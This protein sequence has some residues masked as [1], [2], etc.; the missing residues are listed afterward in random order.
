MA[1]K[2][3]LGRPRTGTGTGTGSND[4]TS[5]CDTAT[6]NFASENATASLR[7][8]NHD[9]AS[10]LASSS[11]KFTVVSELTMPCTEGTVTTSTRRGME[12][13]QSFCTP[14]P[15]QRPLSNDLSSF[16][17]D[18]LNYK[19][20]QVYG[21]DD[22]LD[23]LRKCWTQTQRDRRRRQVVMVGGISGSGKTRLVQAALRHHG[24][25]V[26]GKFVDSVPYSGI[27]TA[28]AE[29]CGLVL[30][31]PDTTSIQQ[32]LVA[33]NLSLLTKVIPILAEV[34]DD[35]FDQTS[36]HNSINQSI[37]E[38]QSN[39][40]CLSAVPKDCIRG[41]GNASFGTRAGRFAKCGCGLSRFVGIHHS[42]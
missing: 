18:K 5:N 19:S 6:A 42:Y 39:Q 14:L 35:D 8:N 2:G 11:V 1:M 36:S 29:I 12:R 30:A 21:R 25:F 28:C 17:I 31:H 15:A 13:R 32:E 27:A 3:M 9:D 22:E 26:R 37:R 20:L 4:A 24:N 34:V 41:I 16:T 23:L 10:T 38:P 40:L 7:V 33:A